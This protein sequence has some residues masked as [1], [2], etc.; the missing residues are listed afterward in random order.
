VCVLG[1]LCSSTHERKSKTNLI[2]KSGRLYV[3]HNTLAEDIPVVII[4]KAR[5]PSISLSHFHTQTHA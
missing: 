4:L 2:V 1:G 5:A 3:K